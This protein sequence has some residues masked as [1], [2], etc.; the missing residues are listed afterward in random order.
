M[1]IADWLPPALAGLVFT[2]LGALKMYGMMAGIE[3]G[4]NA[5]VFD[6]ACGT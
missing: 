6:R 2:A 5:A 3:G 1:M 4:R